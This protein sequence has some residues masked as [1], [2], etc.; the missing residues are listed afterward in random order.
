MNEVKA[1]S[2]NEA[3]GDSSR[4]DLSERAPASA[5]S[6]V[7]GEHELQGATASALDEE[8]LTPE[9]R[10]VLP[11][12]LEV[13]NEIRGYLIADG[14]DVELVS[15]TPD[16]KARVR[17]VGACSG[18]PHAALTLRYGVERCL[19]ENIPEL[20]GLESVD[21]IPGLDDGAENMDS[22]GMF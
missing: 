20:T 1:D 19:M 13:I 22:F 5:G 17:L 10:A 14:G 16:M 18:C 11:R 2:E 3:G 4:G 9:A 21:P 8:S 6:P 12:V 15:I 7:D